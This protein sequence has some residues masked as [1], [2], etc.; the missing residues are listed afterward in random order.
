MAAATTKVGKVKAKQAAVVTTGAR[1]P[2]FVRDRHSGKLMEIDMN[3]IDEGDLGRSYVFT[4]G[5]EVAA[6]HEAVLDAPGTFE[7]VEDWRGERPESDEVGMTP[8]PTTTL[9]PRLPV[10]SSS[11]STAIGGMTHQ[12]DLPR[13]TGRLKESTATMTRSTYERRALQQ[14]RRTMDLGSGRQGL[15]HLPAV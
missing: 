3:P 5:E 15:R 1:P 9:R 11:D 7:P 14:A 12:V 2:M 8:M 4:K 10:S 6:D 13:G